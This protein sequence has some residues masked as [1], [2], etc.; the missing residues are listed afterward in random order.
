MKIIGSSI[1]NYKEHIDD[2]DDLFLYLSC[3]CNANIETLKNMKSILNDYNIDFL[4]VG[5][6]STFDKSKN[7]INTDFGIISQCYITSEAYAILSKHKIEWNDKVNKNIVRA[8]CDSDYD[9]ENLLGKKLNV[10]CLYP[11]PV[12]KCISLVNKIGRTNYYLDEK[13]LKS[14]DIDQSYYFFSV[15]IFIVILLLGISAYM[16]KKYIL[17]YVRHKEIEYSQYFYSL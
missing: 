1:S 4:I 10:Y 7:K 6:I 2:D 5:S 9:F 17:E 16:Y 15:I 8:M 11:C 13:Q 3:L 14:L 12:V